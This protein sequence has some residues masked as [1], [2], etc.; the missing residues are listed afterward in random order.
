MAKYSASPRRSSS[1]AVSLLRASTRCQ[2]SR[3]SGPGKGAVSFWD[4][5]LKI[6]W[7]LSRSSSWES[8]TSQVA[9]VTG[10]SCQAPR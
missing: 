7:I 6:A 5:C 10:H 9:S 4:W 2:N 1:A 3:S 8:G